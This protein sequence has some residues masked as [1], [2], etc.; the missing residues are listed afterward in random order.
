MFLLLVSG[1]LLFPNYNGHKIKT[2]RTLRDMQL[3]RSMFHDTGPVVHQTCH[4]SCYAETTKNL[5]EY[6]YHNKTGKNPESLHLNIR[7]MMKKSSP[8]NKGCRGGLPD[9]ILMKNPLSYVGINTSESFVSG[10]DHLKPMQL[11]FILA[12]HG[13]IIVG[14]D[15]KVSHFKKHR[16]SSIFNGCLDKKIPDHAVLL[17]GYD[18]YNATWTLKNS[19]GIDWG[20]HGFFYMKDICFFKY[21]L[22]CI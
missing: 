22:Y 4:G 7:G 10:I 6:V 16:G 17:V 15:S 3:P 8:P 1:L 12:N 2:H 13:P 11:K 21:Y 14:I 20:D 19:Y 18:E 5:L 9:N